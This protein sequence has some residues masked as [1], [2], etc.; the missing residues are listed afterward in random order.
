M[1]TYLVS[2][3]LLDERILERT[4]LKELGREKEIVPRLFA[5]IL[6]G[7]KNDWDSVSYYCQCVS[8]RRKSG[9]FG[10]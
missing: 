2:Q 8:E 5:D 7:N 4:V 10:L 3:R 9:C 6:E 1:K